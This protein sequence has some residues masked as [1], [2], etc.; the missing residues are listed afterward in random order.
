MARKHN[1]NALS[2]GRYKCL[3]NFFDR[4][5]AEPSLVGEYE[6]GERNGPQSRYLGKEGKLNRWH[7]WRCHGCAY[8]LWCS[9]RFF[10]VLSALRP[11]N[12]CSTAWRCANG[13]EPLRVATRD[14]THPPLPIC[15]YLRHR[16]YLKW[17]WS[18]Q[19]RKPPRCSDH[20]LWSI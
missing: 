1:S 16:L 2:V 12:I 4:S 6:R 19:L 15:L 7:H 11:V 13:T 5:V 3:L 14:E 20:F 10:I 18:E 17:R 8:L 9:A